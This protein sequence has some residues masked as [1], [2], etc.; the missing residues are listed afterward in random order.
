LL[1]YSFA[2]AMATPGSNDD[3]GAGG[4]HYATK[5]P[6]IKSTGVMHTK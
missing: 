6:Q 4:C 3:S 5:L 2:A 1:R